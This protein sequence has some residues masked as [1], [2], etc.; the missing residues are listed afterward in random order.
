M[1]DPIQVAVAVFGSK[2]ALARFLGISG[3]AVCQW[4][5]GQ[6]PCRHHLKIMVE[7]ERRGKPL[8]PEQI[9]PSLAGR[10]DAA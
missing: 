2:K 5:D 3:P 10:G 1:S 6:I 7:A 4:P 8:R 9:D